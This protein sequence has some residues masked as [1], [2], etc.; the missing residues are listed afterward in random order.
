[1]KFCSSF[2]LKIDPEQ[3][4]FIFKHVCAD[5]VDIYNSTLMIFAYT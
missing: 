1:M 4:M 5:P 3:N 2:N